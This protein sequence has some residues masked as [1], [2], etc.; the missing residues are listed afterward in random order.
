MKNSNQDVF[1]QAK[2][3]TNNYDYVKKSSILSG[4]QQYLKITIGTLFVSALFI[5]ELYLI[6]QNMTRK[7]EFFI[8]LSRGARKIQLVGE[9]FVEVYIPCL[10]GM[11]A[12]ICL[13]LILYYGFGNF[14]SY[15]DIQ[16]HSVT[17]ILNIQNLCFLLGSETI[18]IIFGNLVT[19]I[20]LLNKNR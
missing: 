11:L 5:I 17:E 9:L 16:I 2:I 10:V 4:M 1:K 3:I 20:Y 14:F 8:F 7:R 19:F 6:Y 18:I 12:S 15:Q 13:C